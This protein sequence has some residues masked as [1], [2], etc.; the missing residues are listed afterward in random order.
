MNRAFTLYRL[1]QV[2]S[3]LDKTQKRLEEIAAILGD[4]REVRRAEGALQAAEGELSEAKKALRKAEENTRAQRRKIQQTNTR[5]YSGK[6]KN[7]K[8]LQDLQRE[9]EALKRYLD[10]LEERQLEA[11][12]LVDEKEAA[13]QSAHTALE[14]IRAR[15]IEEHAALRG[16][17]SQLEK[18]L[19][20]L[21]AERQV[22]LAAISADD[23]ALYEKLRSSRA[24]IAVARVN[25]KSC[26]ACGSSL[27]SAR[28]QAARS[29]TQI[30]RCDTCGRILYAG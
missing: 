10:V 11:M 26:S 6:V 23:L 16:E 1:Q 27:S 17:Q 28:Y 14:Q 18:D 2:D 8:E 25:D 13:F 3:Q 24:G 15:Q 19:G 30:T 4:D 22:A 5:L 29:P 7:P 9:S 20:R 12:L 21:Q